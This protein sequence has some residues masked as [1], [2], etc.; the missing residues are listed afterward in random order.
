MN[1]LAAGRSTL[2][3]NTKKKKKKKKKKKEKKSCCTFAKRVRAS[4]M[5][6]DVIGGRVGKWEQGTSESSGCIDARKL[7]GF[8]KV[9]KLAH[10]SIIF[11]L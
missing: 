2:P 9:Y 1:L 4:G 3:V 5:E 7:S 8:R 11:T 6:T 10:P